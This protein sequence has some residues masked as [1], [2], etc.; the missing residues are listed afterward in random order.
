MAAI[1]FTVPG[2]LVGY[3]RPQDKPVKDY[4]KYVQFKN[5]VLMEAMD[6]GWRGRMASIIEHPPRLSVLVRW[7]KNPRSDWSNIYKAIE[8]ALF[9]QDRYVKPGQQQGKEWDCGIEE[10]IVVI[11]T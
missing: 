5:R 4:K 6:M 3:R 10:A 2:P 11:E 1:C 8:D 9:T 7:E